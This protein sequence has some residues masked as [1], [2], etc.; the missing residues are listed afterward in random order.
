MRK[1]T[2]QIG[3][4]IALL[5]ALGLGATAQ[6][7]PADQSKAGHAI[8]GE[9]KKVDR[10]AGKMVV[11]M[12]DGTEETFKFTG[13]A[14][15]KGSHVV[16]HYVGE[17]TE[18]TAVGI[19]HIGKAAPKVVEGTVVG[20]GKGA[21]TVVVKTGAGAEETLHLTERAAVDTGEGVVKGTEYTVKEGARVTVHYTEAGGRKVV[22][23]M[24]RIM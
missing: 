18:K 16:V 3:M 22:H 5:V 24:K 11:K 13:Q 2:R 17:G 7:T 10:E 8:E 12:A 21:R 14:V 23:L 9:V 19:E 15:K 6:S 20:A 4:A 1:Q